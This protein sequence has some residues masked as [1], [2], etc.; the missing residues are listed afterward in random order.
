MLP[1][2]HHKEKIEKTRC[3]VLWY[4]LD[5]WVVSVFLNLSYI[6][7][8]EHSTFFLNLNKIYMANNFKIKI[9]YVN[10]QQYNI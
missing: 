3:Y 2:Y 9:A 4:P 6:T 7:A 1:L 5:W 8:K 10:I